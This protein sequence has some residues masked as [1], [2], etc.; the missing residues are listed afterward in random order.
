MAKSKDST[1]V[2]VHIVEA[3]AHISHRGRSV[4]NG[5]LSVDGEMR[6]VKHDL[7]EAEK[8]AIER[9][10]VDILSTNHPI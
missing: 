7:S 3:Q 8:S 4:V 5:T 6:T 1:H 9:V 2:S 10:I